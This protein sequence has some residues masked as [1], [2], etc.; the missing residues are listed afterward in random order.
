MADD[1]AAKKRARKPYKDRDDM[2]RLE[3]SWRKLNGYMD[4]GEWAAAVTRAATAAEIAANIAVRHELVQ[5]R[6]LEADFVDHLLKWA[7]GLAG[8]LDKLLQ[9][10]HTTDERKAVFASVKERA[11]RIN[12]QRN[13]VVH[14]GHFMNDV[15]AE[16]I[17]TLAQEFIETLVGSYHAGFTLQPPSSAKQPS[18]KA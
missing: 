6:K 11:T 3:D 18:A 13:L 12:A 2:E 4:R 15:E 17:K 16:E 8:K 10:L 14:S 7:N 1:A 9:P 5:Q